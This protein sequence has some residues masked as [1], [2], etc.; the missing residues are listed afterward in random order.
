MEVP[1]LDLKAQ[2]FLIKQEIDC[3][4][5]KVITSSK[6][7]S[8]EFVTQFEDNFS[9]ILNVS[10]TIGVS[11]GT[12]ALITALFALGLEKDDEV[13]TVANTFIASSEAI[14][15][16]GGKVVFSDCEADSYNLNPFD[17]ESKITS[18]T[19]GVIAV[20]L[21]GQS[22]NIAEILKIIKKHNLFLIEDA[23]QSFLSKYGS[24]FIGSFGDVA[25]FSFYPSKNLGA[26]GDAGAIVTNDKKIAQKSRMFINHGR[27]SKYDHEFEGV[28]CRMDGLQGAILNVKLKHINEWTETRREIAN[29]YKK[30]LNKLDEIILPK[31]MK[32][33]KHVYHL[34]VI[35]AKERD[36]LKSYLAK[37]GI[38]TGIHYPI[39]LPNLKAYEYLKCKEEDFPISNMLSKQILSLPI[40]P[41]MTNSQI[42]YVCEKIIKFYH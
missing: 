20:H 35:R 15:R 42:E 2:Y 28:N 37:C 14:T 29:N 24:K 6:F 25:T 12:D 10:H 32:Y 36:K 31:E 9:Q 16:A 4:I 5:Q 27:I 17:I 30:K 41:E 38:Q 21:F 11:N 40:Y 13:I 26:F 33:G 18:K 3:A 8:G 23:S 39:I 1:F 22:A 34:F 7:V 19:K